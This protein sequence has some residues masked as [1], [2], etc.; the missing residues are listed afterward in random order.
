MKREMVLASFSNQ[1][2]ITILWPLTT[3]PERLLVATAGRG[4]S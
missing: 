1:S 4:G 2:L 3:D